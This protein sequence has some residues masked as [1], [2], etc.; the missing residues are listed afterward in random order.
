M[1]PTSIYTNPYKARISEHPEVI[2]NAEAYNSDEYWDFINLKGDVIVDLG[3][4]ACNFLRQY[5]ERSPEARF[6]G[7]ELRFKRLHKGAEKF[8]KRDLNNIRLIRDKAENVGKWFQPKTLSEV[9]INFPDPWAKKR[10]LKHRLITKEYLRT[11]H[12]LLNQKGHFSFKTDHQSYFI[13]VTE[14]IHSMQEYEIEEYSEDLHK[15]EYNER[16]I[17][18]EFEQ[19]FLGKGLVTYYLKLIP[20]HVR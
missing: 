17:P 20:K 6:I 5:A 3:C 7:F 2:L 12:T 16:N 8:K 9:H 18:T 15:S 14:L 4:G 11:I 19:L 10:Q 1:S 13:Y